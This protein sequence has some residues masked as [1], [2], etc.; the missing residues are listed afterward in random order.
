MFSTALFAHPRTKLLVSPVFK[1]VELVRVDIFVL[2]THVSRVTW[3]LARL[4]LVHLV[5][6]HASAPRDLIAA[7]DSAHSEQ[8]ERRYAEIADRARRLMEAQALGYDPL[9]LDVEIVSDEEESVALGR[10]LENYERTL[11]ELA[12][13]CRNLEKSAA[14]MSRM[15]EFLRRVAAARIDLSELAKSGRLTV[16]GGILPAEEAATFQN[17]LSAIPNLFQRIGEIDGAAAIIAATLASEGERMAEALREARFEEIAIP[18]QQISDAAAEASRR[19]AEMAAELR[20]VRETLRRAAAQASRSIAAIRRKAE[21]GGGLIRASRSFAAVGH[22]MVIS[23]WA[24]KERLDEV[25]RVVREEA[26]GAAYV[27][28]ADPSELRRA[29]RSF[30]AI[31]VLFNN[32]L[33]LKPFEKITAAYGIPQYREVEPTAFL[34]VSFLIMFGV[35]FGDAGQGAVLAIFGY[36]LFRT[37]YRYTDVGVL[38]IECGA[39]SAIFGLL[40]GSV[41]GS[42]RVIRPIWFNPMRNVSTSIEVALFFGAALISVG[43]VLNIVNGLRAGDISAAIFGERGLMGA[44]MYWV[45]LAIA[46]KYILTGK[47]GLAGAALLFLLGIPAITILLRRP[48]E[49]FFRRRRAQQ[50]PPWKRAPAIFLESLME[51]CDTFLSYLANTVSFIRLAAFSLAHIGL[52]AAV[53]ALADSL[54]RMS[55][56]GIFYWLMLIAGNAAIIVL[57]GMVASIQ[58]IRLEYYEIFSKFFKGGGE[59]FRPLEV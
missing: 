15:A 20:M 33:L 36:A 39:A 23:G 52:F 34:A 41:F 8:A 16:K 57:E 25:R 31:P 4:R 7:G 43:L 30:S 9:A 13:R 37:S 50:P 38:L 56:G 35:M 2:K 10:Q 40:Y 49:E 18:S 45:C 44:F 5:D 19:D 26:A 53:F 14:Q 3:A 17:K 6:V 59:A 11:T 55:G 21:I 12:D 42:E 32:P 54:S 27:E 51:L 24:P 29:G 22:T 46:T 58:A 47:A 48:V 1:P 28:V